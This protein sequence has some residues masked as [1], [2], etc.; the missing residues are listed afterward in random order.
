LTNAVKN[1]KIGFAMTERRNY[2]RFMAKGQVE[3]KTENDPPCVLTTDLIDVSFPGMAVYSKV[4]IDMGTPV[5][6]ELKLEEL[7]RIFKGKGKYRRIQTF[8]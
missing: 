2:I 6:F 5:Q 7:T 1:L 3:L 4:N 8:C